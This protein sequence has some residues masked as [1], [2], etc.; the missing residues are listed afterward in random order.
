MSERSI[1]QFFAALGAPLRMVRQSWGAVRADGAVFLR[2]WQ[3]RCEKRDGIRYVQLTHLEKYGG[4]NSNFG[5][6]ERRSH[7]DLIREGAPCYLVMCLAKDPDASPRDIK[8][9]NG[10]AVFVGGV[11]KQ[12]DEDWWIELAGK[13]PSHDLMQKP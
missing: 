8:S 6:T 7:V 3:D 9:F 4:D 12:F 1:T 10:D 2:V 13:V 11:L 5:Y